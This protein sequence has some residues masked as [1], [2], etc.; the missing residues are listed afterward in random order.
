MA[1]NSLRSRY[2]EVPL[3]NR[4]AQVGIFV[5]AVVAANYIGNY[6][7]RAFAHLHADQP[8]VQGIAAVTQ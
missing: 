2:R 4:V 8:A 6:I 7:F 3:L 5:G 1:D